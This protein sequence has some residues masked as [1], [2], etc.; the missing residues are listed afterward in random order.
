MARCRTTSYQI[1][2]QK[3]VIGTGHRWPTAV[4]QT[5]YS[6]TTASQPKPVLQFDICEVPQPT[7][8]SILLIAF[9]E[10]VVETLRTYQFIQ[11]TR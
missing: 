9:L 5:F 1:A 7:C 11:R 6:L 10:P 3:A 8:P 4:C 2:R